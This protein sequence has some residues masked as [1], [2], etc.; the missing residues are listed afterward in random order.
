MFTSVNRALGYWLAYYVAGYWISI[1]PAL[2]R[3]ALVI[4][5]RHLVDALVDPKRYRY[6]GPARLLRWIWLVMP[7]P[8]LMRAF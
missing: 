7:K 4:H 3:S 5:D 8:D 2:A 6:A 1:R